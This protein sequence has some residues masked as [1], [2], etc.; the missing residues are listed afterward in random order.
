MNKISLVLAV[1]VFVSIQTA[2]PAFSQTTSFVDPL[3]LI[4]ER[5]AK[6]PGLRT[7]VETE[8][9][10]EVCRE[11]LCGGARGDMCTRCKKEK[12]VIT[13]ITVAPPQALKIDDSHIRSI[14]YDQARVF[15]L[16][17]KVHRYAVK[18]RNCKPI[19]DVSNQTLRLSVAK[20]HTTTLTRAISSSQGWRA[21]AN[22][23]LPTNLFKFGID[24]NVQTTVSLTSVTQDSANTSVDY[25]QSITVK[26]APKT[27]TWVEMFAVEQTIVIPFSTGIVVNGPLKPNLDNIKNVV[28]VL[29][30][31]DDRTIEVLGEIR[32]TSATA[33]NINSNSRPLTD[34]ECAA[35]NE[36]LVEKFQ[37]PETA[38]IPYL[39]KPWPEASL[40]ANSSAEPATVLERP[41]EASMLAKLKSL[42]AGAT[43][44][45]ISVKGKTEAMAAN[46][47]GGVCY[48]GPCSNGYREVCYFDEEGGCR[49]Y[50]SSESDPQCQE[51]ESRR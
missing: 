2:L 30:S 31:N 38:F 8:E 46:T 9:R 47:F 34:G 21:N 17:E 51:N 10:V 4:N 50:C 27:L 20:G 36:L 37:P 48:I 43:S 25:S 49:G 15:A 6:T 35:G 7:Q 40:S 23:G 28:D 16:P 22:I 26:A 19:E 41:S 11:Q 45:P 44:K 5:L 1:A 12:R 42:G 18:I 14:S 39:L 24:Y 29:K 32:L 13:S 3:V 33:A